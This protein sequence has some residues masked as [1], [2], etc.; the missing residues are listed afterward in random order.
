VVSQTPSI[1]GKI[2][3][4]VAGLVSRSTV[5]TRAAMAPHTHD[6]AMQIQHSFFSLVSGEQRATTGGL[7]AQLADHES[8]PQWV[9]DTFGFLARGNGQ[10][11]AFLGQSVAGSAIGVGLGALLTNELAPPIQALIAQNPNSVIGAADAAALVARGKL[12]RS[13]MDAEARRQGISSTR[14]GWLIDANVHEADPGAVLA[15]LNR[16][17]VDQATAARDLKDAGYSDHAI[18]VILETRRVPLSAADAADMV[19]RGIIGEAEGRRI[20]AWGG[21]QSGDFDL[22]AQA[23][24]QAL[25]L[26]DL[27]FLYRR[28]K[29]DKSR[30][31]HGIRQGN[32]RNEW[33]PEAEMLG[34]IPM[35]TA[36]A[37]AAAVQNQLPVTQ[38]RQ[39]A[40]ENG[41]EPAHFDPL[42]NTAGDPLSR[43][44]MV[45]LWNLGEVA[46]SDVEQALREGRL[47]N[48]YIPDVLKLRR[49]IWPPDTVRSLYA[50]G[51]IDQARALR[52]LAD[53]GMNT[54]DSAAYL[55]AAQSD[56][57][58]PVKDLTEKML[59]QLY[60][61]EAITRDEASSNLAKLGYDDT[62]IAWL[63]SVPDLQR[64]QKIMN[65]GISR[66]HAKFIAYRIDE[67]SAV[68]AMDNLHVPPTQRDSYI[69]A[70]RIE[71]ELSTP[72]LTVA[73][74]GSALKKGYV[75]ADEMY[76][77][78]VEYGYTPDDAVIVVS[79][80]G[81]T[82]STTTPAPGG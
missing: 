8:S 47:K 12:P 65:Q 72:R 50:R 17:L 41:L 4:K 34:V 26:Q 44:E 54:E 75:T 66:V 35:S 51:V 74:L 80:Y 6:L 3:E 43:S 25:A 40:L 36:D 37:I 39:I 14:F 60:A 38:A 68:T 58:A 49:Y 27:L 2:G 18:N 59:S 46:Q 67:T 24:G 9:K 20:A 45:Q 56:K 42:L 13:D 19:Q 78:L 16:G 28:G 82:A 48:K 21:M 76:S 29:I 79:L 53:Y 31:E 7:F 70:W 62:E 30:L 77:R 10:W 81:G 63:L 71:R 1:G 23:S 11:Q 64:Q 57:M 22:L 15:A 33:I 52:G 55:A 61:D 5:T 73:Q 32:T 69:D